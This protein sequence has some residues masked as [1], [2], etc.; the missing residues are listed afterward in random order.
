VAPPTLATEKV[1]SPPLQIVE[2]PVI[3][4]GVAGTE[5]TVTASVAGLEFPQVLLAVTETVPPLE[6]ATVFMVLV[7]DVPVQ[8]PGS[9]HVYEV[10]PPTAATE[11]V[12]S[13]PL[14]MLALPVIAPGVAGAVLIVTTSVAGLEFPQVLLAVTETVPPPEPGTVLIVLVVDVP[15]QPPGSDHVYE[16]APPTAV[17]E[18]V[19]NPPLHMLALP[20]IAPGVAGTE[21]TVM[22][23]V[24]GL[25]FPQVL[26]AVTET[27]PPPEPATVFMVLVVE[28]PVQPTGSDHVYEV[29][30]PT[31]ATEKVSSPPLHMVALPEIMPGV[32]GAVLIVTTNVAG[33]E[34]PQILL[35]VTETVPPAAL[36]VVVIL[37]LV[38]VPVHPPG[39]D[40]V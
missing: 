4:P 11:N 20:V 24:A 6:P 28:V 21:L 16:V 8:P 17:T 13:P 12:S 15:V 29:A 19:S 26:L 25:E 23:S 38:E 36:A 22:A 33:L 34:L 7:V 39:S 35:A 31:A 1:S 37:L 3:A 27:V 40:H 5:L 10:A 30:P 9:D 18:K 14:Q 32:V 2:R